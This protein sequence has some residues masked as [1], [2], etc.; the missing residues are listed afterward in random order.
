[1]GD[2]EVDVSVPAAVA[3]KVS[4]NK[5]AETASKVG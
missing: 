1:M 5:R 3:T 4:V 2:L